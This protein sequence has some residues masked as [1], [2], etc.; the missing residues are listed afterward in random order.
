MESID[1]GLVWDDLEVIQK[2]DNQC[3]QRDDKWLEENQL[4]LKSQIEI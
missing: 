1:F 4:E 2:N 3:K